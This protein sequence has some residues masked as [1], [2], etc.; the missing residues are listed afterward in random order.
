MGLSLSYRYK[1]IHDE[2]QTDADREDHLTRTTL[3]YVHHSGFSTAVSQAYRH[4][5]FKSVDRP[6]EG[7]WITDAKL[8][9]EFPHKWGAVSFEVRNIFNHHFDWTT[10]YF[11]LTGRAPARE[12]VFTLSLNF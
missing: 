3:K 8:G 2:S 9:Y 10:D 11:V 1:D 5:R 4:E 6:D 12:T 7:I